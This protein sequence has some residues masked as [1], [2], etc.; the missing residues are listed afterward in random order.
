[1]RS[2]SRAPGPAVNQSVAAITVQ[3][4]PSYPGALPL[5]R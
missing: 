3:A 5:S 4:E 2:V 1:M